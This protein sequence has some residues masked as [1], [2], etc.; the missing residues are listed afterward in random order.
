MVKAG[1][2]GRRALSFAENQGLPNQGNNIVAKK[3]WFGAIN[4]N[5]AAGATM[6]V[7]VRG[8]TWGFT[9]VEYAE[10]HSRAHIGTTGNKAAGT[11]FVLLNH[12]PTLWLPASLAAAQ[13]CFMFLIGRVDGR[14]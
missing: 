5:T 2:F 4:K 10:F 7:N 12:N 6:T 8:A 11:V 1:K 9:W 13:R 14:S 3:I